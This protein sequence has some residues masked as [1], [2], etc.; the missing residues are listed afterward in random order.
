VNV[1]AVDIGNT[2]VTFGVVR[3]T[4]VIRVGRVSGRERNAQRLTRLLAS[5]CGGR[6][7]A[8]GIVGSVVPAALPV[9]RRCIRRVTGHAPLVLTHRLKLGVDVDYPKPESIGADRLANASGAVARYGA[10]VI[11]ADFGTALTFDIVSRAG[12][13]IGGVIAP[14]LPLMLDYLAE[15]TALLPRIRL[16]GAV[17][18]VGRSTA[19]AMRFGARVGYRGMVREITET[20]W[21][22]EDLCGARLCATG[23]YAAWALKGSGLPYV[24]DPDLTLFGLGRVFRLNTRSEA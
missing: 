18:S 22:R 3:G 9:W 6:P 4:R 12:T 7:P 20:L 16:A 13:Y 1:L 19:G 17:G 11:V 24:I 23:G 2:S 21:R 10:P 15:R 14:G 8:R 5:A